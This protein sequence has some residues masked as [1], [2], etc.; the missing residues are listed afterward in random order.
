VWLLTPAHVS[1]HLQRLRCCPARWDEPK[2]PLRRPVKETLEKIT[3]IMAHL[4][5]DLKV[6]R[7]QQQAHYHVEK[8]SA[9]A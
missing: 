7:G 9:V 8:H 3:E 1:P 5:D 6:G 2:F 4:E